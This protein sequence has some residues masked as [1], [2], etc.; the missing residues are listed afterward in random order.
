MGEWNVQ[1]VLLL[2][3]LAMAI[4]CLWLR[5][6]AVRWLFTLLAVVFWVAFLVLFGFIIGYTA[7]VKG[8]HIVKA[9]F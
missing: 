7:G 8:I 4:L 5:K 2:V 6:R 9:L 3:L 1:V